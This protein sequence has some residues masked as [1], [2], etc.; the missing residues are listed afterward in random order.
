MAAI[1]N[2]SK[3]TL[4][5]DQLVFVERGCDWSAEQDLLPV[6]A[7]CYLT[8]DRGPLDNLF[9][10]IGYDEATGIVDAVFPRLRMLPSGELELGGDKTTEPEPYFAPCKC[11]P[12]RQGDSFLCE[13]GAE[14]VTH[15]RYVRDF[16]PATD[17][18]VYSVHKFY[19]DTNH[20]ERARK[21]EVNILHAPLRRE[22]D[23]GEI[24][25]EPRCKRK[26]EEEEE[27]VSEDKRDPS[28]DESDA[29]ERCA[30]RR[31]TGEDK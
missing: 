12:L 2:N 26:R 29:E 22:R 17:E 15:E 14:E 1:D 31:R 24:M 27:D 3:T 28:E 10:V 19:Y 9:V 16:E 7:V 5:V 4:K 13:C 25:P 8:Y 6:G 23:S 20:Y 30:K 18:T 21:D 11:P